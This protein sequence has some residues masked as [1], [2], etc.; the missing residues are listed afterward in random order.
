LFS[1]GKSTGGNP[2]PGPKITAVY[3]TLNQ[4]TPLTNWQQGNIY[5]YR[6]TKKQLQF[7]TES[8][9]N[10]VVSDVS[11]AYNNLLAA[12][13]KIRVNQSRLLRDSNEVARLARRSYQVGQ[14][15][16]TAT[17][18]ALQEN[19]QTRSSYLQAVSAYASAYTDLEVAVG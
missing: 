2:V 13:E 3:M 18:Q 1:F 8:Q 9:R 6:A 16:I 12:R 4:E 15:D 11:S 5:Q 19:V 10:Q 14:S 7:Q 17:L